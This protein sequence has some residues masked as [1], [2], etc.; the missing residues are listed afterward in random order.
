VLAEV[1]DGATAHADL[2]G[3]SD[4]P[5]ADFRHARQVGTFGDDTQL[6]YSLRFVEE[7]NGGGCTLS[8]VA[9]AGAHGTHVAA[10]AGAHYPDAASSAK[11]GLSPG[12]QLISL[13]IGDSRLGTMETGQS[14]SRAFA[15]VAALSGSEHAVDLINLSYGEATQRPNHG[16]LIELAEALV[17][18]HGVIFVSS[19]GNSGPGLSS[20]TAPGATASALIG[21]GAY[22]TKGMKQ[23]LDNMKSSAGD[24][25]QDSQY[26]F[27][28]RGPSPDGYLGV[29]LSAP[30]GAIAS[31]P[32]WVGQSEQL[33][34]GT[35]MASP[36]AVGA[37]SNMLSGLKQTKVKYSPFSVRRA[38]EATATRGNDA[39]ASNNDAF[40]LGHGLLQV[41]SAFEAHS[42]QQQQLI[43][44]DFRVSIPERNMA[45]GVYLRDA[46]ES[47]TRQVVSASITPLFPKGTTTEE[48]V[49]FGTLLVNIKTTVSW[50]SAGDHLVLPASGRPISMT[51]DPRS[52]P[53]GAHF[54]ELLGFDASADSSSSSPLFRLPV[55][56]IKPHQ[57]DYPMSDEVTFDTLELKSGVVERRFLSVPAGATSMD[58][59]VKLIHRD[60]DESSGI[61]GTNEGDESGDI[62]LP[63]ATDRS[64]SAHS[65]TI[66]G[67]SHALSSLLVLPYNL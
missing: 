48:K 57:D 39:D 40:T 22:V 55:S 16:R 35:S 54:G 7:S 17:R 32:N 4:E 8:V 52:L 24:A 64:A 38:L 46:H 26:S 31:V 19:A 36:N 23:V 67:K 44:V 3:A 10:I 2:V 5:M 6:H 51:I 63:E 50:L 28:S 59:S 18:D 30:G 45:P 29:S 43:K 62:S 27:S 34:K 13:K 11:D 66:H 61:G 1:V 20:V 60:G 15:A 25:L 9:N 37:I 21:I 65:R 33:M 53:P 58:I 56:V 41:A 14:L 12:A 47:K 42:E 49:A